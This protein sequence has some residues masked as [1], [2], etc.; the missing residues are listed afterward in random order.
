MKIFIALSLMCVPLRGADSSIRVTTTTNAVEGSIFI[1]EVFTRSGQ[2]NLT[3]FTAIEGGRVTTRSHD[4]F[5][6]GLWL[7]SMVW[8]APP[9]SDSVHSDFTVDPGSPYFV[10]CE[11]GPSN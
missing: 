5:H 4:F 6:D 11:F 10:R 9:R 3:R 1:N 8:T 2:T 7:A